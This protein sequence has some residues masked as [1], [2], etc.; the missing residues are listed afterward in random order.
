MSG[1]DLGH[2]VLLQWRELCS[3]A[4]GG[5]EAPGAPQE[6]LTALPDP[7]GCVVPSVILGLGCSFFVVDFV[8]VFVV[9]LIFASVA[10]AAAASAG[11]LFV[12]PG[13]LD[14][15]DLSSHP[16][17]KPSAVRAASRRSRSYEQARP[18]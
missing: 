8:L 3:R 12:N 18:S 15:A 9:F 4:A 16:H 17:S 2:I 10:V 6:P 5:L 7:C 14:V 11:H 1:Y 13:Q